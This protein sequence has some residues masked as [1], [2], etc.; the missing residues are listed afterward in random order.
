MGIGAPSIEVVGDVLEA[1]KAFRF[2]RSTNR[3]TAAEMA[4]SA[5]ASVRMCFV[6]L[7]STNF[8]GLARGFV[9][10]WAS[11]CFRL[12]IVFP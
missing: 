6:P 5:E 11:I 8:H 7:A 10:P 3:F 2:H 9:L 4:A 12:L 1:V